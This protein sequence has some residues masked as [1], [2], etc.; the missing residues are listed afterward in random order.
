MTD[1]S[2]ILSPREGMNSLRNVRAQRVK[3]NI[4]HLTYESPYVTMEDIYD[5][6][7]LI[8]SLVPD[9]PRYVIASLPNLRGSESS[10]RRHPPLPGTQ[11]VA[12]VYASPVGRMITQA[13]LRL[14]GS[15]VPTRMFKTRDQAIQWIE[16]LGKA[17]IGANV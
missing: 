11:G 17:E 10:V 15:K 7:E 5:S 13:Y 1:A 14:K 16:Q 8:Q 12:L 3:A 6:E 9:G 4:I 2:N